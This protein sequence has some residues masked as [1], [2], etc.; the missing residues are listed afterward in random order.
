MPDDLIAYEQYVS[1]SQDVIEAIRL[2]GAC[3]FPLPLHPWAMDL[4]IGW[5]RGE[6]IDRT[7]SLYLH[8][9]NSEYIQ[10]AKCLLEQ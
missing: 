5:V 3:D 10:L 7:L 9:P 1:R 8:M 6:V 2:I 4:I